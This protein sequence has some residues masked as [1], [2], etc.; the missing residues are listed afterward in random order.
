MYAAL[1]RPAEVPKRA[2][3]LS[4]VRPDS[5][6]EP[7]ATCSRVW[8]AAE[9]IVHSRRR[10]NRGR[11]QKRPQPSVTLSAGNRSAPE[12]PLSLISA[13]YA[14]RTVA[15]LA[16]TPPR[17]LDQAGS[18]VQAAALRSISRPDWPVICLLLTR[19]RGRKESQTKTSPR[20]LRLTAPT[21]GLRGSR[22]WID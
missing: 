7:N 1:G 16:T 21:G 6:P 17:E 18:I 15:L 13:A 3:S 11:D 14:Q 9:P 22:R 8:Q 10:P 4:A 2:H 20:V 12:S 19:P 5:R